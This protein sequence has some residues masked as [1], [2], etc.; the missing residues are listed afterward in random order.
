MPRIFAR[1]D[2]RIVRGSDRCADRWDRVRLDQV[3]TNL[4]TNAVKYG[5]GQ[6]ID[7]TVS[8]DERVARLEVRDRDIGIAPEHQGRIFE[9]FERARG[10][11]DVHRGA[12]A[13][14][15]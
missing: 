1:W 14:R 9:R 8:G 11:L 10:R 12:A 4:V 3:V 2:C 7:I 15:A 6:P 13:N 5:E